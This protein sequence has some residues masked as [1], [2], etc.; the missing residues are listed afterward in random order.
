MLRSKSSE[1]YMKIKKTKSVLY[2]SIRTCENKMPK[3][4]RDTI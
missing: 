4:L 3:N 1:T 2:F